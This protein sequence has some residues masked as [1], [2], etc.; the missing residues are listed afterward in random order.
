MATNHLYMCG[1][2]KSKNSISKEIK[3][4]FGHQ[5]P[6]RVRPASLVILTMIITIMTIW[7]FVIIT[8]KNQIWHVWNVLLNHDG[9]Q[10]Q[11]DAVALQCVDYLKLCHREAVCLWCYKYCGMLEY[12]M[13][14]PRWWY[15]KGHPQCNYCRAPAPFQ[16][17]SPSE[18]VSCLQQCTQEQY[19]VS[20]T[21]RRIVLFVSWIYHKKGKIYILTIH[22]DILKDFCKQK[23]EKYICVFIFLFSLE[24]SVC[25]CTSKFLL[26]SLSLQW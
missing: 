18:Q 12:G 7:M 26:Y 14:L 6:L 22:K 15:A 20:T 3:I 13:L 8:D 23:N 17:T 5:P 10:D 4:V 11:D 19:P 24:G 25:V 16:H 21:C 2:T 1:L 9:Y